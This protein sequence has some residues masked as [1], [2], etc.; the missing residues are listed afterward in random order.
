MLYF[1]NT[2]QEIQKFAKNATKSIQLLGGG[3]FDP[4][5]PWAG[6]LPLDPAGGTPLDHQLPQRL[7][8]PNPRVYYG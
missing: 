6:A 8:F 5:N 1:H 2:S 7:Q 3:G 4:Q